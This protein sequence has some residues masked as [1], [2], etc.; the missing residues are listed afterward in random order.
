MKGEI[1]PVSLDHLRRFVSLPGRVECNS[2]PVLVER[3]LVDHGLIEH[4]THEGRTMV[5]ATEAG[6]KRALQT[7]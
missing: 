2:I 4:Y 1:H 7:R 6:R 3:Q 5:R